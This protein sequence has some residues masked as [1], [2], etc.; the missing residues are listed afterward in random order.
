MQ[1]VAGHLR[2]N[3]FKH[4]IVWVGNRVTPMHELMELNEDDLATKKSHGNISSNRDSS[5]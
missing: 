4:C 5:K 2:N 1:I 3:P